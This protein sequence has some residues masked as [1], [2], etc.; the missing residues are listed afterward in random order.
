MIIPNKVTSNPLPIYKDYNL[1]DVEFEVSDDELDFDSQILNEPMKLQE[2]KNN[3]AII[4]LDNE[5]R[6]DNFDEQ[7]AHADRISILE[8]ISVRI[9]TPFTYLNDVCIDWFIDNLI[10]SDPNIQ[11]KML[12]TCNAQRISKYTPI[13]GEKDYVQIIFS[14]NPNSEI[15]H[16]IVAHFVATEGLVKIYDSLHGSGTHGKI[17]ELCEMNILSTRY[18]GKKYVFVQPATLQKDGFSCGV[19]AIAYATTII[20]GLDPEYY[21]LQMDTI[22]DKSMP[23]RKHIIEMYNNKRLDK[24]PQPTFEMENFNDINFA[25]DK[26]KCSIHLSDSESENDNNNAPCFLDDEEF[27]EFEDDNFY[28]VIEEIYE[29]LVGSQLKPI[30]DYIMDRTFLLDQSIDWF[31]MNLANANQTVPFNMYPVCYAQRPERYKK[32]MVIQNDLQILFNGDIK[33]DAIGHYIVAHFINS[34]NVVKIY[35]SLHGTG[36]HGREL[37]EDTRN[38][39]SR[40]YPGKRYELIKPATLQPDGLSCGVFAIAYATTI[41]LERDP[42]TYHLRLCLNERNQT[43]ELRNHIKT[44]YESRQLLLFPQ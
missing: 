17:L 29:N 4:I 13:T 10:I 44:M 2:K 28:N 19:F 1:P 12:P 6:Y 25:L 31:I 23:L 37:E 18:P 14:S 34:E 22:G 36:N 32:L 15:G 43:R 39:L 20:L 7:T 24:F 21:E 38:I 35:D 8:T 27:S 11:C 42:A 26:I 33:E 3:D 41:I 40:I 9:T 30:T 5:N 16:Y